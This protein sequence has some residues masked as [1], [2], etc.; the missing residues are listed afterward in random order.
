MQLFE[1]FQTAFNAVCPIVLLMALGYYLRQ[2]G[3][4]TAEFVSVGSKLTFRAFLPIMLFVNVYSIENLSD[5]PW[6][7]VIYCVLSLLALFGIGLI[8][9]PMVTKKPPQ[10]GVLLQNVFRSNMAIIG[11]SIASYIGGEPAVS[12][13]AVASAFSIPVLN[14]LAVVS[15]TIYTGGNGKKLDIKGMLMSILKNPLIDGIALGFLMIILRT[16]QIQLFHKTV[17]TI[18]GNMKFLYNALVNVK[19]IASPFA[20]IVLG[21]QFQFSAAKNMR[22]EIIIGTFFRVVMAPLLVIATACLLSAYTPLLHC[23]SREL[24]TLIALFGTPTAVSSSIM[25]GQMGGDEQLATQLVVW[26]NIC[27][28]ATIFATVCI[29][30][31]T[32]LLTI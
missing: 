8:V 10:Q 24:P 31:A 22:R 2:K 25:A 6:D 20:L 21:G 16:L 15:L 7:M 11:L 28:I 30:M 9:V 14:I 32:G 18:S 12:V 29:L 26:T 13:A 17:F 1:I 19:S 3:L 27:S 23:G 4:M 5:I